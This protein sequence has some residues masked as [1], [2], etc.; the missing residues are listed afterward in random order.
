MSNRENYRQKALCCLHAA[1][2]V[3]GSGERLALLSLAGNYMA[4][5]GYV[6]GRENRLDTTGASRRVSPGADDA[7]L[8][9]PRVDQ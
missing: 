2:T 7:S 8:A 9:S 6:G 4:L 3:R 5:A 1:H